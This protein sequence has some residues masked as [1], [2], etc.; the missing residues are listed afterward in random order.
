MNKGVFLSTYG[1][2]RFFRVCFLFCVFISAITFGLS[3]S[4]GPGGSNVQAVHDLGY[5][6]EGVFHRPDIPQ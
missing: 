1:I 6:G 5:K 2:Y 3:E 4:T